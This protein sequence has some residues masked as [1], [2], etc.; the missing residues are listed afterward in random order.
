MKLLHRA[1]N[2]LPKK[3]Q[4]G[5]SVIKHRIELIHCIHYNCVNFNVHMDSFVQ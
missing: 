4:L 1:I 5:V 2:D 3:R